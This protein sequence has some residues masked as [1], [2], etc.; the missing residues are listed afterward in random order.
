M[1]EDLFVA[2]GAAELAACEVQLSAFRLTIREAQFFSTG[3]FAINGPLDGELQVER[4]QVFQS[5]QA[6]EPVNIT[7][8]AHRN[9]IEDTTMDVSGNIILRSGEPSDGEVLVEGVRFRSRSQT[10]VIHIGAS[11]RTGHDGRVRLKDSELVGDGTVSI[12]ASFESSHGRGRV[13]IERNA[14]IAQVRIILLVGE[15]GT[16]E[17]RENLQGIRTPGTL[18]IGSESVGRTSVDENRIV[19]LDGVQIH[20]G[21]RT[22]VVENDFSDSGEVVIEGPRCRA[23][24][25]IPQVHCSM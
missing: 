8:I 17:V 15:D 12:Q 10:G 4:S 16:L 3:D 25:N 21:G 24:D 23:R 1:D 5:A 20:S 14:L 19:A 11:G 13:Q 7:L 6:G 18:T 2:G 9:R 22:T